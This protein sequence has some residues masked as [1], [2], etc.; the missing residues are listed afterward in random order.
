MNITRQ[1]FLKMAINTAISTGYS[2]VINACENNSRQE[3]NKSVSGKNNKI[4]G[5]TM[6]K[7][8]KIGED[9]KTKLAMQYS[10]VGFY[11]ADKIPEGAGTIRNPGIGCIMPRILAS[12]KGKTYAFDEK[13][14]GQE[15]SAFFLGFRDWIFP[16]V[17]YFLSHGPLVGRLCEHFVKTPRLAKKYLESIRFREKSK[18]AAVFKP[19]D[20]FT[21][22]EKP[23]IVI[24]FAN[25]DQLSALVYLTY[26]SAPLENDRVVTG[27]ASGCGSTVTLPLQYARKGVKKAVWGL[28]D[29]S[30]RANLPRDLMT[31]TVPYE[32]LVEMWKDAE[33]SFLSTGT[34]D[35]IAQ[36]INKK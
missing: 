13:T 29:I 4:I 26:Y 35:R 18:G 24:F 15:C 22:A 27:F 17:Q 36:R 23:E 21:D 5:A 30:A 20:Q 19:L 9:F 11:F 25:A 28:H 14:T 32:L 1:H 16:G 12:A 6:I 31:F 34:W 10:P 33:E 8:A 3:R 2:G 7:P